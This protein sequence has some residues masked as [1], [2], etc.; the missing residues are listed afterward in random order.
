MA[1][2]RVPCRPQVRYYCHACYVIWDT[3]LLAEVHH[4][5]TGHKIYIGRIAEIKFNDKNI[6]RITKAG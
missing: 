5:L 6:H 2:K 1:I 3:D 4:K